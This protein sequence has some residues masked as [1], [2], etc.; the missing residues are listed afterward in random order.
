MTTLKSRD[1]IDIS[2]IVACYNEEP[3]LEDSI[4]QIE[5]TLNQTVYSYEIIFVDDRSVDGTR[6][7]IEC[8]V[9]T[10][11]HARSLFHSQNT[12]RGR[13]VMDG[14]QLARGRVVG[15][16]DIDLEVHCRYIPSMISAILDDGYD[17]ATGFR[18]Y[19]IHLNAIDLVRHVLSVT[20]RKLVHLLLPV[21]VVDTETGYK[22]FRADRIGCVLEECMSPGWFW[23]TEIMYM[24]WENGLKIKEIPCLFVR[25]LDKKSTVRVFRD[26]WNYLREI[27]RFRKRI[28]ASGG[29]LRVSRLAAVSELSVPLQSAEP[30]RPEILVQPKRNV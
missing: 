19:K 6:A 14:F 4:V 3:H 16:L 28:K 11:P 9:A 13:T 10:R 25:R 5:Q 1:Q 27:I 2:I 22:F 23:D 24:A 12:G 7:V 30:A 21:P 15:F 29:P 26:S 17:V 18:I 20:Y 8:L